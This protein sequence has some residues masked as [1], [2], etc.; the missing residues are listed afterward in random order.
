MTGLEDLEPF[1]ENDLENET[2]EEKP[3]LRWIVGVSLVL[4]FFVSAF[5]YGAFSLIKFII[6]GLWNLL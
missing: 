1:S 2:Q 5:F 3:P 4:L 6:L